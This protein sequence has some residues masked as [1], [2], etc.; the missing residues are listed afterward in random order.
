MKFETVLEYSTFTRPRLWRKEESVT[1]KLHVKTA[2][3]IPLPPEQ[4]MK[5]EKVIVPELPPLKVTVTVWQKIGAVLQGWLNTKVKDAADGKRVDL[6]SF[7]L[8]QWWP[9]IVVGLMILATAL[10]FLLR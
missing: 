7:A 4:P 9:E 1:K 2:K 5:L 6:P 10:Y 3:D 8:L